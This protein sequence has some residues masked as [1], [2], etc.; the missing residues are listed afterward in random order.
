MAENGNYDPS[1]AQEVFQNVDSGEEIKMCMQ[2]GI[3]GGSCPLRHE[4]DYTPRNIFMMV[5]NGRRDAVL[6]SKA[7]TLCTSCYRCMVRC[8]RGIP[9]IDVMHGLAHYAIKQGIIPR[10][11]PA[12]FGGEFWDM[13]YRIGR[14][15]E[16][17]LSRRYYFQDGIVAGIQGMLGIANMAAQMLFHGRVKLL[18]ERK[19]KGI[20][21]LRKMIDKAEQMGKGGAGA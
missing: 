15:D 5:R 21:A 3:C 8:P 13:V 11:G 18:P 19:I 9:V 17:D 7:I 1:F 12:A 20:K 2:C 4:M 6:N 10:K 16:K 14:I